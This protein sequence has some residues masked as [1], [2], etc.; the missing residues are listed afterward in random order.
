MYYEGEGGDRDTL[1]AARWAKL[2]ADKGNVGAQALLGHLLFE[3]DGIKREPVV[4][5]MFLT[6]ARDRASPSQQWILDMQEEALSV[7]TESERRTAVALAED[8]LDKKEVPQN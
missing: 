1:Q 5:L 4:G 2:A 8:W 7:A 6:I 3:G